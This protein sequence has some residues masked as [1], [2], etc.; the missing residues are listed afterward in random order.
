V[1]K[2]V[3]YNDQFYTKVI[4][5]VRRNLTIIPRDARMKDGKKREMED[6][7][8]IEV[9]VEKMEEKRVEL[10]MKKS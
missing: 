6:S 10:P 9:E 8:K 3:K 1:N 2:F 4:D 7:N 5:E